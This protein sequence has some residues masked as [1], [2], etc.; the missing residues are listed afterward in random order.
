MT[1][2]ERF[3]IWSSILFYTFFFIFH[4][5]FAMCLLALVDNQSSNKVGFMWSTGKM[6]T[7]WTNN[8]VKVLWQRNIVVFTTWPYIEFSI[9]SH[10]WGGPFDTSILY[11][12]LALAKEALHKWLRGSRWSVCNWFILFWYYCHGFEMI[13]EAVAFS[14]FFL[15]K[16]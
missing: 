3:Q 1:M 2:S 6:T 7:Y 9:F 13:H 14:T 11:E 10:F 5:F 16:M 12:I 4:V 15:D 8:T